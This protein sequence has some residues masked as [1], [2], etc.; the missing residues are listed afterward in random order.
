[1][2]EKLRFLA[3]ARPAVAHPVRKAALTTLAYVLGCTAYILLSSRYAA[4]ASSTTEQLALIE[5]GKG[6]AFVGLTGLGF[7]A[8]ATFQ[9]RRIHEREAQIVQ[10]EE[11]LMSAERKNVAGLM[12]AA[13][14]HDI[15]NALTIQSALIDELRTEARDPALVSLSQELDASFQTLTRLAEQ[16][17]AAARPICRARVERVELGSAL[18]QLVVLARRHPD[19]KGCQVTVH[20]P[21]AV[22]IRVSR[23]LLE[24]ALLNLVINAGQAMGG[25]GRIELRVSSE[26]GS[27][28]I[29]V[30]DSG[31]GVDPARQDEIFSPLFTTKPGGSGLG[32]LSVKAL[33][34]SCEGTVAVARSE[35]GGALIRLALPLDS[36]APP[37]H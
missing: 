2:P 25:R 4:R 7:F 16:I 33:A 31:P 32:L 30:H 23:V 22:T 15:N 14:G 20:R 28:V 37:V 6:V 27:A 9:W 1:M 21:S 17:S 3:V 26:S 36:E 12:A 11:A 35:L 29:E 10:Q 5:V 13:V 24:E 34:D 19:T 18:D 8:F